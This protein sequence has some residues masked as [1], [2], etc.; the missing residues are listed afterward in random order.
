MRQQFI[1]SVLWD[2][3]RHSRLVDPLA[4]GKEDVTR[5]LSHASLFEMKRVCNQQ[6]EEYSLFIRLERGVSF[7][8]GYEGVFET[9][10]MYMSENVN[11][12]MRS[13]VGTISVS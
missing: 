11:G 4:R 2:R 1:K 6:R 10:V 7:G 12:D 3:S 5:V 9:D 8:F 13:P